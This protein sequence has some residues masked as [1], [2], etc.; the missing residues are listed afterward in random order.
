MSEVLLGYDLRFPRFV[1]LKFLKG[2]YRFD[3]SAIGRLKREAEIY[4][5]LEH[6]SIVRLVGTGEVA[7]GGGYLAQEF[8]RGDS[9]TETLEQVGHLELPLAITLLED[10]GSA[11]LL[12]HRS[13][14][15]HRDIQPQN[16]MVGPDGRATVYDFGIAF[17][18]DDLVHTEIG[19][20]MGTILYSSPEQRRGEKVDHRS[21]IFALGAVFY[22]M[23]TGRKV[24]QARTFEQALSAT[25]E[26]LPVPSS[27]NPMVPPV[28]D[29]ICMH[30]LD[31]DPDARYQDLRDLLVEI[32]HLRV[33]ASEEIAQALFGRREMR[34]IDEGITAMREG[35][36]KLARQVAMEMDSQDLKGV[37]SEANYLVGLIHA[38]DGR[39]DLA[40]RCFEKALYYDEENLD[41]ALDYAMMLMRQGDLERASLMLDRIPGA[42][43]GN[44][45]VLG[46]IDTVDQIQR[47]PLE[48]R[49]QLGAGVQK[50]KNL[51]GS[52]RSFFSR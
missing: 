2:A 36:K 35:N 33:E 23:L 52:I 1:A 46:L 37:E 45:L 31:D 38:N 21:D 25:T 17:A 18:A 47:A 11:L 50:D 39:P 12:A 22:E 19:T 43:R 41:V 30:L 27:F 26:G 24:I 28:L 7:G 20:V 6:P 42:H 44:L 48:I 8:L 16:I 3:Q 15:I 40:A 4:R 51:L 10:M 13:G 34:R 49:A 9:L 29:R 32:G 5:S 14:F